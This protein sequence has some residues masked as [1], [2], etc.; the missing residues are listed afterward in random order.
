MT[1]TAQNVVHMSE[2]KRRFMEK[3][4]RRTPEEIYDE[5]MRMQQIIRHLNG[6]ILRL[7]QY[8]TEH[9]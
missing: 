5:L 4:M 2:H 1:E 6:E 9:E 3:F 8:M 7:R